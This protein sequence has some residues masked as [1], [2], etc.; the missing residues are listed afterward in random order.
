VGRVLVT[1]SPGTG[2]TTLAV[3]VAE[4]LRERRETLAGFT[5]GE[6]RR[7]GRRTGFTVTGMGGLERILAVEGG[8]GP[9]VGRYGVD[10]DA[11]EEVALTELESGLEIGATLIVDEIGKMELFSAP[12]RA[13]LERVFEAP[14]VMATV[15]SHRDPLTDELKRRTDL[16]LL[17]IGPQ[18]RDALV[19]RAL[20]LLVG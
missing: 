16:R 11:F 9:P 10:V 14:R 15:H 20:D 6:I 4:R 12:F 5:T 2:K 17:R 13:L 7:G 18:N 8:E 19:E 3:R 1:G